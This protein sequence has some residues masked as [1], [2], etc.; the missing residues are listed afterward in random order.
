MGSHTLQRTAGADGR[1]NA[2]GQRGYALAIVMVFAACL[3]TV[4]TSLYAYARAIRKWGDTS[5]E[6][7]QATWAARAGLVH[8]AAQLQIGAPGGIAQ[9]PFGGLNY[10][11]TER[12]DGDAIVI[13]STAQS[14]NE[15]AVMEWRVRE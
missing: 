15:Q 14:G 8:R 5:E 10:Q 11:V 4:W 9:P 7:R 3:F 1:R 6:R 12:P 2:P 13:T